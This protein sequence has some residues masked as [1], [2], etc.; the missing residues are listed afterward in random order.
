[1]RQTAHDKWEDAVFKL[2]ARHFSFKLSKDLEFDLGKLD[3][4]VDDYSLRI[5]NKRHLF[6]DGDYTADKLCDAVKNGVKPHLILKMNEGC[7]DGILSIRAGKD[8]WSERLAVVG[9]STNNPEEYL[10]ADLDDY[11]LEK[12]AARL[13][14]FYPKF[15]AAAQ[16]NIR[17]IYEDFF[18]L[19]FSRR[20]EIITKLSEHLLDDEKPLEPASFMN[21]FMYMS[22]E[23]IQ[24]VLEDVRKEVEKSIDEDIR[25]EFLSPEDKPELLRKSNE[26]LDSYLEPEYF[27]RGAMSL[28]L[29]NIGENKGEVQTDDIARVAAWSLNEPTLRFGRGDLLRSWVMESCKEYNLDYEI[30]NKKFARRACDILEM[31]PNPRK[32]SAKNQVKM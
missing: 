3:V 27:F 15:D 22:G 12:T 20:D 19:G 26:R 29:Q 1:M 11:L 32:L 13:P 5:G 6:F 2:F 30:V 18:H 23:E 25:N 31:I 8:N 16:E 17:Q 7:A 9:T 10:P 4:E 28:Q 24:D 14:S 21:T